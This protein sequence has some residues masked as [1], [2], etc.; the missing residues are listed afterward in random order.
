MN[1]RLVLMMALALTALAAW[2]APEPAD[3]VGVVVKPPTTTVQ[4]PLLVEPAGPA[5]RADQ[6]V[7][8]ASVQLLLPQARVDFD[9]EDQLFLVVQP[10]VSSPDSVGPP[11][12]AP[13]IEAPPPPPQLVMQF[14][15]RYVDGAGSVAFVTVQGQNLALRSGE[16][17]ADGF[18][19]EQIDEQTLT[20]RH[21]ASGQLQTV[22]LDGQQ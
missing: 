22:R 11:L 18:R 2:L 16:M 17:V 14:I 6:A 3:D 12:S 7:R 19:L 9:G 10:S 20:V 1:R 21:V 13:P 15:G 4:R 5:Q 8:S